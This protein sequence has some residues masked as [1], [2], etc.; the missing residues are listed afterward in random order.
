MNN[1]T[2]KSS[3]KKSIFLDRLTSEKPG[4]VFSGKNDKVN[5]KIYLSTV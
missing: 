2:M 5:F 3:T 1:V 4:T